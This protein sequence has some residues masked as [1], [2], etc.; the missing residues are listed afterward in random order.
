MTWLLVVLFS[1]QNGAEKMGQRVAFSEGDVRK[2]NKLYQCT[3]SINGN[4]IT[5]EQVSRA[6]RKG[7]RYGLQKTSA[8]CRNSD[9]IGKDISSI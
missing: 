1:F 4:S 6:P 5:D 9:Q 8:I 2:I 7:F 3:P